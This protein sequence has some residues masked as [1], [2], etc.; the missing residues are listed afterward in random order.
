MGVHLR[1]KTLS[2][3]KISLYLDYYPPINKGDGSVTRREFLKRYLYAK[4]K[5]DDEKRS[6]KENLHFAETIRLKRENEILYEKEGM[7]NPVNKKRDFLEYFRRLADDRKQSKGNYN[8]W[9]SALNYLTAFTG[10]ICKMG[11]ITEDFCSKFKN[12][13][14]STDKLKKSKGLKLSHNSALS[15]F[16]KFCAG[17]AAAFDAKYINED[18]LKHVKGIQQKETIR[19][20]LTEEELQNLADT[21]C[22]LPLLKTAALFAGLTGLR[23]SDIEKLKWKDIQ[24]T[25]AKGYFLHIVQQKTQEVILHPINAN[26][27]K[28]LGEQGSPEE[29]IFFGLKYSDG[30]NDKLKRWILRAG[31]NKKITLHNFRHSYATILLDNGADISTVSRMIGHKY[32]KSTMVYAKTKDQKKINAANLIKINL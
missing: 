5:D 3:G 29:K 27:V 12:Y 18:P 19:E 31:I 20:F 17:V 23:W 4:P 6:N 22:E 2:D 13:L 7:F 11:D 25:E 26:S 9:L 10:G 8:N 1:R 16:N 32:I 15:Y 24:H 14:L 21:N 28:L 30:N